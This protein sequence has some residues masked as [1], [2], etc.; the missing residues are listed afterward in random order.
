MVDGIGKQNVWKD[1]LVYSKV[2]I[3]GSI[4]EKVLS[5]LWRYM[6]M[7][8]AWWM[9]LKKHYQFKDYFRYQFPHTC[10]E[11]DSFSQVCN[12]F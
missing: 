3:M 2:E 5:T 12:L 11:L 8:D 1:W 6:A 7:K 10:E 9:M 4:W